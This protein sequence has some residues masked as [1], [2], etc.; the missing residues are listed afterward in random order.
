RLLGGGSKYEEQVR[1]ARWRYEQAPAQH[2]ERERQRLAQLKAA[3]EENR[4]RDQEVQAL[5]RDLAAG[6]PQAVVT[7][8][9]LVFNASPFPDGFPQHWRLAYVPDSHQL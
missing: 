6:E 3:E 1:A 5:H 7:Y 4:R 9:D 8:L 2:A